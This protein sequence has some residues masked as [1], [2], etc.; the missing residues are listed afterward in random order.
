ML[1]I[2]ETTGNISVTF[3]ALSYVGTLWLTVLSD[4]ALASDVAVLTAALRRE[5]ASAP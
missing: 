2:P 5:L 3:A 1:P 4:P